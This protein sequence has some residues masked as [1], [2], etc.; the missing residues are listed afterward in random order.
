MIGPGAGLVGG[1]PV[2]GGGAGVAWVG[3][4]TD[5]GPTGP[6]I[7]DVEVDVALVGTG[8]LLPG[9]IGLKVG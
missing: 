8:G 2:V 7:I 5:V 4:G 9:P 1:G 3:G 6:N